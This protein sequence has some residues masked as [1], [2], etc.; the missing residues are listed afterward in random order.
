MLKCK[1]CG[2]D[3]NSEEGDK[4]YQFFSSVSCLFSEGVEFM[5]KIQ[6]FDA[7]KRDWEKCLK[8]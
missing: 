8:A 1:K 6:I 7:I 2:A 5:N 4:Y 3:F